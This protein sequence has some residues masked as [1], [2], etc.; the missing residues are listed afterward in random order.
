MTD[1]QKLKDTK[2]TVCYI[3][4]ASHSGSTVLNMMLAHSLGALGLGESHAVLSGK[5]KTMEGSSEC[6][7]CGSSMEICPFWGGLIT[8]D[9]VVLKEK[10]F[11]KRYLKILEKAKELGFDTIVDSS[12]HIDMLDILLM[13][14]Q[15]G[16]IK[17]KVLFLIRDVRGWVTSMKAIARRDND[18]LFLITIR[19][20]LNWYLINKSILR[21]L[22][23]RNLTYKKVSYEEL[24]FNTKETTAKI[25]DFSGKCGT[26]QDQDRTSHI[27]FGNRTKKHFS[28]EE[29]LT[30]D[31]RWCRDTAVQFWLLIF[32]PI[33]FWNM[34]VI[35]PK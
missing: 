24:V 10:D 16:H 32:F 1:F 7:S 29:P 17:L 27:A 31:W 25:K 18:K 9:G 12:K 3:H 11:T 8:Q 30:Y 34:R 4:S 22:E 33:L 26:S 23:Q 5:K 15:Q 13:L 21:D 20:I 6:C 35:Y 19:R 2:M 14:E 28:A